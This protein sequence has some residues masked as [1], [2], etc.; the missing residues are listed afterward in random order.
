MLSCAISSPPLCS[1]HSGSSN[2]LHLPLKTKLGR[3]FTSILQL[4][5]QDGEQRPY[6]FPGH[7]DARDRSVQHHPQQVSGK[8]SAL[9]KYKEARTN[10]LQTGHAMCTELRF[11]RPQRAKAI[12]TTR[13]PN[14]GFPH[15]KLRQR[16]KRQPILTTNPEPKCS[17][18]KWAVSWS[19]V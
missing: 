11:P 10:R 9:Y 19:S 8:V 4:T 3:V 12:R 17:L 7:D 15:P 18:E 2:V 6:P 5:G 14:V 13:H 1:P 16:K